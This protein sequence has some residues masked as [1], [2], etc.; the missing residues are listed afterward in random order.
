MGVEGR[1]EAF[2]VSGG[3]GGLNVQ[4][5]LEAERRRL[6]V[7][8]RGS[9][10]LQVI[11]SEAKGFGRPDPTKTP[12]PREEQTLWEKEYKA[13]LKRNGRMVCAMCYEGYKCL[14]RGAVLANYSDVQKKES[15]SRVDQA[16]SIPSM[17]VTAEKLRGAPGSGTSDSDI[18]HII[19]RIKAYNPEKQFVVV[20]QCHG[21]MGAD[22]VTPNM[23]P[24]DVW[25]STKD[26]AR[27]TP[28]KFTLWTA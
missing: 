11:A 22:I 9:T 15:D 24:E 17:Y 7:G 8:A 21:V 1:M 23:K 3:A 27:D 25:Q 19:Q 4:R 10:R 26:E 14:G 5:K 13:F 28:Q 18:R 2:V 20:F 12:V 16:Q 6:R